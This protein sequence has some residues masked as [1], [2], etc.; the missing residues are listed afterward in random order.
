MNDQNSETGATSAAPTQQPEQENKTAPAVKGPAVDPGS[1]SPKEP[2]TSKEPAATRP[3]HPCKTGIRT[4]WDMVAAGRSE[5]EAADWLYRNYPQH[6]SSS[7]DA[8][9]VMA[10][11]K[12]HC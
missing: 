6:F 4:A 3:A 1:E 2:D 9:N 12:E 11:E 5:T 10:S 7:T 8:G